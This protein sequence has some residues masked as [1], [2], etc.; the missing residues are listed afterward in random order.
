MRIA[1]TGANGFVGTTLVRL[2]MPHHTVLAIDNLR[3]GAWRYREDELAQ[4]S[5]STI[6]LR[7]PDDCRNVIADFE[8][9]AIIHL[10]AIHFIPE[11]EQN[12]DLT[13]TTNVLATVNLA[14][15]CPPTCR[16]VLAS[17]GAVYQPKD[18][19]HDEASD[20]TAP[21]DVYGFTK[22]H[23]EHFVGYYAARRGF[24]AVV[25]RLFN[26]VGPGETNPH[27]LPE[28]IHQIQRGVEPIRLGNTHPKR[29]YIFVDD[30]A[31]GFDAVATRPFPAGVG[32]ATVNLGSGTSHSV[33]D[34]V[35]T[36]GAV[37]GRPIQVEIDPDRVRAVD[38]P[39]LC[40]GLDRIRTWFGW[41]PA[42]SFEEGLRLT[43][44]R[45]EIAR[46]PDSILVGNA[47]VK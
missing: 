2:L 36:L 17:S 21:A 31:A 10:A 4:I 42:V 37:R 14:S 29:D 1:V 26:V 18:G 40:A 25:V 38:R 34:M 23:A 44:E 47:V 28:I 39:D 27:L 3:Y 32:V 16:F 8:P 7:D 33:D 46:S 11:C 5:T 15:V 41:R 20:L 12:P 6:D 13:I 45:P 35:A 22:L 30:V 9:D 43:W 19:P 24:D